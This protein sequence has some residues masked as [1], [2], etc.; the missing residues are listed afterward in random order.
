MFSPLDQ[1]ENTI[2]IPFFIFGFDFSFTLF[3]ISISFVIVFFIFAILIGL[4]NPLLIPN[5]FQFF[6]ESLYEFVYFVQKSQ[7]GQ[8]GTGFFPFF[9]T[10][11]A[12]IFCSNFFGLIPYSFTSTA[13]LFLPLFLSLTCNL[14]FL[15]ISFYRHGT[16]FFKFFIPTGV[17]I[18]LVPLITIIEISTY[19]LRT[20]SLAL[21]LFANM[22]AGHTLLF[23]CVGSL[24]AS[25]SLGS[26][27]LFCA[28]LA[29]ILA[30]Y[31]LEMLIAF[32]QAYVFLVLLSVYLADSLNIPGHLC[33][34][35]KYSGF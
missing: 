15:I 4:S 29:L 30:I 12:F 13:Q 20:F 11:F 28:S 17:S 18:F 35:R 33:P 26:S 24:S 5:R 6:L 7:T 8:K 25:F 34:L 19:F 22:I 31:C 21:R 27:I 9:F 2:L 16:S 3:S 32:L 1:F 10:I 23:I 14:S